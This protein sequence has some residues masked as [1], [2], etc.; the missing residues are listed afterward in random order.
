METLETA[1]AES[2][3]HDVSFVFTE[4]LSQLLATSRILVRE[5]I[6]SRHLMSVDWLELASG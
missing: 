2:G 5:L 1:I 3:L 4:R 6:D